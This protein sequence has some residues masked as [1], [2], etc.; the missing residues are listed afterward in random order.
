[1]GW[2]GIILKGDE[3]LPVHPSTLGGWRILAPS[4]TESRRGIVRG[5]DAAHD[6]VVAIKC[7]PFSLTEHAERQAW[8]ERLRHEATI[9]A[10]LAHPTIVPLLDQGE[11]QG[12]PYLVF[13][14]QPEATLRERLD[15]GWLPDV[16]GAVSIIQALLTG[17]AHIHARGYRHGD[18]K[19]SNLF[20]TAGG[21]VH[22]VDFGAAGPIDAP[23]AR[24][25]RLTGTHGFMPPEQ[26]MGLPIDQRADLFAVGVILH[27][28]LTG[29]KP[30]LGARPWEITLRVL[31]EEPPGLV[32]EA[33]RLNGVMRRALAKR[34]EERFGSAEGFAAAL[35]ETV[36]MAG[37]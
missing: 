16:A 30:F 1:M 11:D 32:G 4:D 2:P 25:G 5:L 17:V 33:A 6:R 27:E 12:A 22:L 18:L 26:L 3:P 36:G 37:K 28:L 7:V 10:R 29:A 15:Q 14:W 35:K 34:P 9:V 20:V 23:P 19:P 8:I 24:G 21:A 31:G 13:A